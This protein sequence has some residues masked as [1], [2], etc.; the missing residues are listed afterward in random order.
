MQ[1]DAVHNNVVQVCCFVHLR[2]KPSIL[3]LLFLLFSGL[4]KGGVAFYVLKGFVVH[5]AAEQGELNI[6]IGY[7]RLLAGVFSALVLRGS[8]TET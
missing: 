8:A 2:Q 4:Y 6:F 1:L 5:P 3:P 7:L